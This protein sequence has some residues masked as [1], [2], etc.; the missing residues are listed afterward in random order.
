MTMKL[1][2]APKTVDEIIRG[3]EVRILKRLMAPAEMLQPQGPSGLF[4]HREAVRSFRVLV[5]GRK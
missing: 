1:L 5:N 2:A 4:E 3:Y